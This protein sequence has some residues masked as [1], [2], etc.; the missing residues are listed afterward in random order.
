MPVSSANLYLVDGSS[1][2]Y[3]AYYA[4]RHLSNSK[5]EA[6]NA[7][8]GFTKMLQTLINQ[9]HPSHL[10]VVFDAKGPTFRKELYSEYKANRSAMPEDLVPQIPLIKDVVR[11]FKLPLLELQGYEADDIIATLARRYADQGMKVTVVTGDKDL[12]QIVTDRVGLLDTMKGKRSGEAEVIE[13]FGVPP[14]QVLEVLG[15]AGDTSDNIPGVPGIGEKTASAL[16]QEFGDIEN[17]LA[18]IDQVKGAK[19][20]ENLREFADQARLSRQLA[21][22]VYDLPVAIDYADLALCPPD[23]EQL[24]DLYTRLEFYQ[25]LEGLVDI[26]KTVK[27]SALAGNYRTVTTF[28]DLEAM[29]AQ[30]RV[31]GRFALDTETTSLQAVQAQLVGLSFALAA[32]SGWYVP[33]GHRY[34]GAPE[35]LNLQRVLDALRPLLESQEIIKVGQNIKYDALV[36][37]NAGIELAGIG[38]DTMVL[39]YLIYPESKSH[40][41]DA[42]ANDHLN[43]RMIPYKELTGTG[44]KQIGFAEVEVEKAAVYAA[45]DADITWQLAE[46]LLPELPASGAENL[47]R[48]IEMPLVEVLTRMEWQGIRVDARFLAGLSAEMGK[49]LVR[50]EE[51]IHA[52]AGGPFNINSPKQLGE[53]LFEKLGLPRGKKTKTGWST[54]VEV[55]TELGENHEIAAR[56][57]EYRSISKLKSTYTDA[58]PQLINP[59]SGRIHTSYNQAVTATGRLSSSDPNL[60]N[61]P[62]RSVEGRRIR[63]AFL[64]AEGNLL[65]AADYSQIE[66]RVMAHIADV[67][68]LKESFA[69]GEDIHRRTASE[70]FNVFPGMVSDEMRRQ[71]KTINFGV[72]YGMGAFS[73]AKDLGIG[74]KE[75]QQ[76]IDSYFE[77][78]PA[79]L[80]FM[81][82]RKV[83]AREHQYVTTLLGRRCAIPEI[84]SKNG[85]V[86]SYAERNAINYPIQGSAADII[87][88]A[89]VN[90]DRRLRQEGLQ[91]HMVL[92]VHDELVFDVPPA[93][94]EL[95]KQLVTLEMENAVPLSVPVVVDIGVGAN[96]SE[97]H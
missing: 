83:E 67:A 49:G 12:M 25:L 63:E 71:A 7:V 5:G 37:R 96:W 86:R 43:H 4:I 32:G 52:L 54:N 44:Q 47:Y 6:T 36:L 27:R 24:I 3:R 62:I 85:A 34:L 91:T 46:K 84:N 8:F 90:I 33:V 51:E 10:A 29:I 11:A 94:L 61:I 68:A 65:L 19:R 13:R 45:E 89:M 77:R 81:E 53:I 79:V 72:L 15:L 58:L 56:I 30:L 92:Q 93:E 97:A 50:L 70:I 74:R 88:V 82:E 16:I 18:N 60:Q 2:I 23:H 59:A 28:A 31:A 42:L 64:P 14:C 57:L 80:S 20:Q 1:Y 78:Y 35:Q 69:A 55:L 87:K 41:L 22:L 76:F 66:L 17:L 48:E 39:S 73:L 40:G 21:D 75:A 95:I 26:E 9:E 38:D